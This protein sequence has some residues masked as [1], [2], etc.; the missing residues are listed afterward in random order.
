[1][2]RP[3]LIL[4]ILASSFS[5]A[6]VTGT[7]SLEKT[8]FAPGEPVILSLTVHNASSEPQ[9]VVTADPYSFCSGYKIQVTQ[10][11]APEPACFQGFAGS[12]MSGALQL[13]PG[14]SQTT[15]ILLNFEDGLHLV[16]SS[17]VRL[18][19]DYTINAS[20]EISFG[21]PGHTFQ[22]ATSTPRETVR[23]TFR[24]R[25][26][27]S[28]Q[29]SAVVYDTFVHQLQSQDQQ[30]RRE[31]AR[32]L[33]TLAPPAL[34]PLLLTFATSK[35]EALKQFAPLA[36]SNLAT[37]ASLSALAQMLLH[38]PPGSY[39]YMSAAEAL[40]RTRDPLWFRL[41]LEVADQHGAMYLGYAAESGGAAAIP[42]LVAR[43]HNPG[44][45]T[46][47]NVISALG[48]TGTRA[49]AP[50]L[51]GLLNGNTTDGDERNVVIGANLA[52]RELTHVYADPVSV[53]DMTTWQRRWQQWWFTAGSTAPIYTARRGD[54]VSDTKLP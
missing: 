50:F 34:E 28:L 18:P 15:A 13:A 42:A 25:V 6:Q 51:I 10:D 31:A 9:E 5:A 39:E 22:L 53:E 33:A 30:V 44:S 52:L 3:W 37:K 49:A 8:T 32:T 17:P 43:F 24:V 27:D 7:F 14:A 1:M 41:L 54:C 47:A 26:D 38:T 40:G 19:G 12:C 36:L 48:R 11:S 45:D 21:P 46:R 29:V 4:A 2:Q 16:P 23:Q 35:D 20:R